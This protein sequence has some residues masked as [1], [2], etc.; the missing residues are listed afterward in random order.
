MQKIKDVEL[1]EC[2]WTDWKTYFRTPCEVY[3]RVMW[4]IRPFSWYNEGK[5]S[6]FASRAYFSED[7]IN[8]SD[9]IRKYS[10]QN[11]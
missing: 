9:F 6:E 8:N 5:K 10:T 11:A 1:V 4:Y 2:K 3:T 7:K